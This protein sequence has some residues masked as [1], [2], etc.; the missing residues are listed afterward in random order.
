MIPF[1]MLLPKVPNT[2]VIEMPKAAV[3]MCKR[4]GVKEMFIDMDKQSKSDMSL[5]DNR[6]ISIAGR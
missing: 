6:Q 5:R 3:T 2:T 4:F 1:R